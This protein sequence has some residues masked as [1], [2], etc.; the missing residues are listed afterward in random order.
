ME[1]I[2][3]MNTKFTTLMAALAVASLLSPMAGARKKDVPVVLS[4]DP[5]GTIS[6][7][8]PSTTISLEVEAEMETFYAGPY[9]RFA[10]KYLGVQARQSNQTTH[11]IIKVD[12]STK[13]EADQSTRC[14]LYVGDKVAHAPL[15]KL[16][17]Q[18]LISIN[19]NASGDRVEW[20]FPAAA[21]SDFA[22][23]GVTANLTSGSTT[24]YQKSKGSNVAVQQSVVVEK[25]LE[26]RAAEA[27]EMI[28]KFRDQRIKI[29]TGDTD[30]SYSGEAMA[31][32]L[33]ELKSLEK[34][35]MSLFVGYSEF[36]TKSMRFDVV[37][38][39]GDKQKY[40]AFR[41]S[42]KDGLLPSDNIAGKPVLMEIVPQE[43][44]AIDYDKKVK[45]SKEPVIYYRVPSIC[46]V[47][48]LD[49]ADLLLNARVP[50]YQ[51]GL[52]TSLPIKLYVE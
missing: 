21:E 6:Y 30:A 43:V 33:E 42:D 37:P 35:Y 9:A 51:L 17:S 1:K 22:H 23:K 41:I 28:F 15:L 49:G 16:T 5:A 46:T 7:C 29:L 24:L 10:T 32:A 31:A 38:V 39:K 45:A 20:N 8:L 48:L 13:V 44:P 40:I 2:L 14:P 3:I 50:V 25:S 36:Q 27:A 4:T 19:D 26:K 18:G 34:E 12:M 11:K 52:D 47:R